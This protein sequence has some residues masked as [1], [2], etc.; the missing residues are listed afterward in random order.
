MQLYIPAMMTSPW[1]LVSMTSQWQPVKTI[2]QGQSCRGDVTMQICHDDVSKS[3][4]YAELTIA[5]CYDDLT[6]S[7]CH[8]DVTLPMYLDDVTIS[9]G[10]ENIT[11]SI[12]NDNVTLITNRAKTSG[13][14]HND[15]MT[16]AWQQCS[17]IAVMGV[18][19][20]WLWK[21]NICRYWFFIFFIFFRNVGA[22]ILCKM[23]NS[24]NLT[25]KDFLKLIDTYVSNYVF[26]WSC[27]GL[28]K[29]RLSYQS[30]IASIWMFHIYVFFL[31][32]FWY[33][34]LQGSFNHLYLLIL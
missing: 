9:N 27:F 1:Q 14:R 23:W 31:F 25:I 24:W 10:H 32:F 34:S 12:S 18:W 3:I 4:C 6:E 17:I 33:S 8:D 16:S 2:S 5:T 7:N 21:A 26:S 19:N 30:E 11:V 29:R 20:I 13:W 15:L 22:W 28:L